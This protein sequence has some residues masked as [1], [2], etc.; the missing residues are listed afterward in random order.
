MATKD[1]AGLS[2]AEAAAEA[3]AEEAVAAVDSPEPASSEPSLV[4]GEVIE[5]PAIETPQGTFGALREVNDQDEQPQVDVD[6]TLVDVQGQQVSVGELRQG[7]LRQSDY[8][9]KTQEVARQ[10][11][12][13]EKAI[14]LWDALQR[15]PAGTI[16]KLASKV[17][18]GQPLEFGDG[19][20]PASNSSSV[21]DSLEDKVQAAVQQALAND[22]R[23]QQWEESQ[24]MSNL[25]RIFS[26]ME[27]DHD[28]T[29]V[30][31][32]RQLILET[33][34]KM[35]TTDLGFVLNGLLY[36]RSRREGELKNAKGAST[37]TGRRTDASDIETPEPEKYASFK[38]AL[39]ATLR[40]EGL[41]E[42]VG[43]L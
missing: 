33:A 24:A 16:R 10:K 13:H 12:E 21:S 27:E 25:D 30:D 19:V 6:S 41:N 2:F 29:L 31:A 38:D 34:D 40:E 39:A 32:D 8:T 35:Q 9:Q 5:Q 42:L 22:P 37:V 14:T 15:D 28:I 18:T 20:K 26:K 7:Y 36:E 4:A 11:A 43:S 17:N 3:M 23:I 1:N